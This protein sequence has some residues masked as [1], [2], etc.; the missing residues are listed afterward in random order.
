[1][2]QIEYP[3]GQAEVTRFTHGGRGREELF[4]SALHPDERYRQRVHVVDA[5]DFTPALDL[6]RDADPNHCRL[7]LLGHLHSQARHA[8]EI[9]HHGC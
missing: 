3:D 4:T 8:E 6:E 5:G 9:S 1:M 7:C 2:T